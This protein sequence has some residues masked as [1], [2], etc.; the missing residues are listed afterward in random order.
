MTE[1]DL[2]EY[3]R[4]KNKIKKLLRDYEECNEYLNSPK[5]CNL[6]SLPGGNG[7][8][9]VRMV[10]YDQKS[11]IK[12]QI[13]EFINLRDL[14]ERRLNKVSDKL[15]KNLDVDIFD[16]LYRKGFDMSDIAITL[17]YTRSWIS[18]RRKI[19]LD[20]AANIAK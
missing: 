12:T 17:S 7:D 11:K 6:T 2:Y 10:F 8:D 13:D 9:E 1:K 19:I 4:Y 20:I 18:K 5:S 14:A 16:Y 15:E 3:L